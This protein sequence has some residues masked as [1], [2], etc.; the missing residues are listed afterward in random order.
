MNTD[1]QKFLRSLRNQKAIAAGVV[2]I[3]FALLG[4][5]EGSVLPAVVALVA[6]VLICQDV[7]VR[8]DGN[9][10]SRILS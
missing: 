3:P 1:K 2:L 6:F 7:T 10:H 5:P 4:V 8:F 9:P